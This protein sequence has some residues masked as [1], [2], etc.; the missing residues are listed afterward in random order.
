MFE[1]TLSST[2]LKRAKGK[3]DLSDD[4]WNLITQA[5]FSDNI[6][7]E[8][9]LPE[10][11]RNI[12]VGGRL[13]SL[14]EYDSETGDLIG[15][16][17]AED[18]PELELQVK[19]DGVLSVTFG[20]FN[21]PFRASDSLARAERAEGDLLLW[22]RMMSEQI[23]GLRKKLFEAEKDLVTSRQIVDVKEQEIEE[24]NSDYK[25]IIRDLEDRFFQVLNSKKERIWELEERDP[26]ELKYL[27]EKY[28][29]S[30]EMNL[31]RVNVEDIL[32][33]EEDR[34]YAAKKR[35]AAAKAKQSRKR[36]RQPKEEDLELSSDGDGEGAPE[37]V[38]H[39]VK[40]EADIEVKE[41]ADLE[42]Q[43]NESAADTAGSEDETDYSDSG[44][45]VESQKREE[46][47]DDTDYGSDD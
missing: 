8:V 27:N 31:N 20:S 24:T 38:E 18:I 32:I 40:E 9:D 16:E 46:A 41:E 39:E 30:N 47:D 44:V 25:E 19:S 21:V 3:S 26:D 43:P 36:K 33:G 11:Y 14:E 13:S 37:K 34:R 45:E 42:V 10:K 7:E 35:K 6:H 15:E 17:L 12:V 1:T 2:K 23:D 5:V 28:I 29:K 22:I 4:D